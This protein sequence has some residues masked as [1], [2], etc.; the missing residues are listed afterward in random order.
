MSEVALRWAYYITIFVILLFVLIEGKRRQRIIPVIKPLGNTT[1]EFVNVVSR[2]YFQ[3]QDHRNMT[4]KKIVFFLEHVRTR[5]QLA[6]NKLDD[7]FAISLSHKSGY[8]LEKTK[9]LIWKIQQIDIA[10]NI[11]ADDL[12][13]INGDIEDFYVESEN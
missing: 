2:L 7:A 8:P 9:Y 6:T 13:K 10:G 3:K 1:L 11:T 12:L 5:Y 4:R